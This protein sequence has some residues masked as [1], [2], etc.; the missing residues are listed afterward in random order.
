MY[1]IYYREEDAL[2]YLSRSVLCL[3]RQSPREMIT[4][5]LQTD[6]PFLLDS[7]K[8]VLSSGRRGGG[9]GASGAEVS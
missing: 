4:G 9:R 8:V 3:H 5:P 6:P 1:Y 2:E 7:N